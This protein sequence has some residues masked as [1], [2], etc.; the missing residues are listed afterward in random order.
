MVTKDVGHTFIHAN[1]KDTSAIDFFL[2]KESNETKVLNISKGDYSEN[3]SDH[4]PVKMTVSVNFNMAVVKP[5]TKVGQS[6][7]IKWSKVDKE[8]CSAKVNGKLDQVCYKL[9][10]L[11][12]DDTVKT[13]NNILT[14]SARECAPTKGKSKKIP[15]LKVMTPKIQSAIHAKKHAFHLCK[16]NGRSNDHKYLKQVEEEVEVIFSICANTTKEVKLI[17]DKEIHDALKSLNQGK[18]PD[19]YGVNVEHLVFGGQNLMDVLKLLM[20]RILLDKSVPNSLKQGILNPIFKNK[21]SHKDS[22]NYRGITITPVLTRLLEVI[23]KNRIKPILLEKQNPL[24]RGF[25]ENSSPMNC[26]LLVEEFYRNN[27]D[28][29]KPTYM[30]FLDAKAAFDV[31]VHPNLMRKLYNSG[32]TGRERLLIDSLHQDSLTSIKWLGELLPTYVNQQGVRQGGVLSA[33]MY[34]VYNNDSLDRI[35]ESGKGASISSIRVPAP[36]CAGDVTVMSE[37]LCGLQSVIKISK[38]SSQFD[39]Y[40]LQEIKSVIVM[41]DSIKTYPESESWTLG[42]KIMPITESTTHMGILRTSTNQEM[43][44]VETNIQKAKRAAYSIMGSGLHGENGQDPETALS[45]LQTY[46][47]PILFYGLEVILPSGK[48]LSV[49]DVQYKR[50]LKQILSL[51]DTTTDPAV[52]LLSGLLPAEP[53]I[54]KRVFTLFGNITRLADTSIENQLAKRQLEIKTFK[55]H[56]WFVAVKKTLLKYDLP[57]A[58]SLLEKPIAKFA[59]KK[60]FNESVNKYWTERVLNMNLQTLLV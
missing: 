45:L 21:G 28:L 50:L 17:S 53:V 8:Q 22:Q 15:K 48:A 54:H 27:K 20:N 40:S 32:V 37:G 6:A 9:E 30:A 49:L 16:Q 11:N 23:L 60:L 52:Y 10:S 59:W 34:K 29:K 44:N 41:M 36:T 35:V 33:D 55:S 58:E 5:N 14:T 12:P 19:V 56:S 4:Y 2:Y 39:G 13:I 38:D 51:P 18:A 31:V 57:S 1:G 7:R 25:T 3:V 24:Q 47:L 46:V 43:Q 42:S 26:A